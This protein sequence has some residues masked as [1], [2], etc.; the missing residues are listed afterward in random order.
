MADSTATPAVPEANMANLTLD[1]VTGEMV[2]KSE[3][4]KRDKQ[5]KKEAEKAAKAAAKP[6]APVKEKKSNAEAEEKELNPNVSFAAA[7]NHD[8]F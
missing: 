1:E 3:W 6:A 4:K 5:R 7:S 2:S 8:I